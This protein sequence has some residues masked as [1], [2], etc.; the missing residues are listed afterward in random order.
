MTRNRRFL[1]VAGIVMMVAYISF[2]LTFGQENADYHVIGFLGG[3]NG[4]IHDPL[5]HGIGVGGNLSLNAAAGVNWQQIQQTGADF[6]LESAVGVLFYQ[7]GVASLSVFAVFVAL[8]LMA[9]FNRIESRHLLMF[10]VLATVAVNGVFQEEAYAPTA[11]GVFTILCAVII[12]NG[13][14]PIGRLV[15]IWEPKTA[16]TTVA[17]V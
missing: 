6:A 3:V 1:A 2:G 10:I 11:A 12:A 15:P 4:L 5:G 17:H 14:R 8:L 13:D 9:P 7:M 16:R